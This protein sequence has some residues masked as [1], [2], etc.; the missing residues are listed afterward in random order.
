MTESNILK[1]MAL[2]VKK[3]ERIDLFLRE[4][5]RDDN[6]H[7]TYIS[8]TLVVNEKKLNV[9]LNKQM[10]SMLVVLLQQLIME[11]STIDYE[12]LKLIYPTQQSWHVY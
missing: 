12:K 3:L 2:K 10:A 1:R 9:N 8:L 11:G 6:D 5:T 7:A 4:G